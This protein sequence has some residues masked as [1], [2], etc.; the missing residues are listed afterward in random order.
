MMPKSVLKW[1]GEVSERER[2]PAKEVSSRLVVGE[3]EE[4]FCL[5]M[6]ANR[7]S[8]F[9]PAKCGS[10]RSCRK[11][12]A[13][14]MLGKLVL[15]R[16]DG[17]AAVPASQESRW[18]SHWMGDLGVTLDAVGHFHGHVAYGFWGFAGAACLL[19]GRVSDTIAGT[20]ETE[21]VH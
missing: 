21:Y 7:Q 11:D 5:A 15:N 9:E 19:G 4:G 3:V 10:Q 12:S 1:E 14:E 16:T 13:V 20:M 6:M 8:D 2:M 17:W 18:W